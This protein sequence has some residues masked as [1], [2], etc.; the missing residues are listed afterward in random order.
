MARKDGRFGVQD[1]RGAIVVEPT[2]QILTLQREGLFPLVLFQGRSALIVDVADGALTQTPITLGRTVAESPPAFPIAFCGPDGCGLLSDTG[3]NMAGGGFYDEVV[4]GG[5]LDNGL[6]HV[7]RGALWG[8]IDHRGHVIAPPTWTSVSRE[9]GFPKVATR[10]GKAWLLSGRGTPLHKDGVDEVMGD[11]PAS[12]RVGAVVVRVGDRFG[13]L[14]PS[15]GAQL[16]A[17]T[18]DAVHVVN[19]QRFVVTKNGKHGVVDARGRVLIAVDNDDL[20]GPFGGRYRARRGADY[21]VVNLDALSSKAAEG[22]TVRRF[23][24]EPIAAPLLARA[25]AGALS[26]VVDRTPPLHLHNSPTALSIALVNRTGESVA[27]ATEDG[28]LVVDVERQ[29]ADGAWL[30]LPELRTE[31]SCGNSRGQA[32]LPPGQQL[33]AAFSRP[34]SFP[35]PLRFVIVV[36]NTAVVSAPLP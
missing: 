3:K 33:V 26:V 23:G 1:E 29:G 34:T 30:R 7:R 28:A 17:P 5:V 12:A 9:Q 18:W 25:A 35:G 16:V 8:L 19:G 20:Q 21:R 36:D 10:D 11:A 32:L 14:S 24:A 2:W 4:A 27:L 31:I 13:A 15:T 22:D 6:Y